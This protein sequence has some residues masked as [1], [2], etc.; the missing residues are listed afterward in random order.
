MGLAASAG[1]PW[2]VDA[3]TKSMK[4]SAHRVRAL[5]DWCVYDIAEDSFT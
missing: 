4:K 3:Q 2:A 5:G 1:A